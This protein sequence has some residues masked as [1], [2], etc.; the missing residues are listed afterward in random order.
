ME[1]IV[2]APELTASRI[3]LATCTGQG[4]TVWGQWIACVRYGEQEQQLPLIVIAG[5]GPSLFGC[6]WLAEFQLDWP[7]I[8]KVETPLG[9]IL[10]EY[11]EVFRA[12][13]CTLR[14]V[15]AKLEVKPGARP[16]FHKPR[17]EPYAIK[18]AIEKNLEW[19]E[20]AGV[21]EMVKFSDC[22]SPKY[23]CT[24]LMEG[25]GSAVITRSP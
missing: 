3:K 2:G 21:L 12:E 22:A 9:Q 4:L 24:S 25:S 6:K 11:E 20:K 8:H 23:L 1:R 15:Q 17:S 16:R 5:E 10:R 7:S 19:L 13:L 18:Q 14:G